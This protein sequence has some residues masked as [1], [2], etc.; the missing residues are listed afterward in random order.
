MHFAKIPSDFSVAASK[1]TFRVQVHENDRV[2]IDLLEVRREPKGLS[3]GGEFQGLVVDQHGHRI[4]YGA[5]PEA[6]VRLEWVAHIKR[7]CSGAGE[8]SLHLE[9][10]AGEDGAWLPCTNRPILDREIVVAAAQE[11]QAS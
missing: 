5:V 6:F 1:M 7:F 8:V 3:L 2:H 9:F 11:T 4:L 10:G